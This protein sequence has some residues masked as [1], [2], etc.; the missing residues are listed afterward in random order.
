[1]YSIIY[2]REKNSISQKSISFEPDATQEFN[3]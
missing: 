3:L 2:A 1:M